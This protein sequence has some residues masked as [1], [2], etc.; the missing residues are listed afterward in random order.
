MFLRFTFILNLLLSFTGSCFSQEEGDES[1][2]KERYFLSA[3]IGSGTYFL[4]GNIGGN[5]SINHSV[6][7]VE[8]NS[9]FTP[10][11]ANTDKMEDIN[12]FNLIYSYEIPVK[13]AYLYLGAGPSLISGDKQ[14]FINNVQNSENLSYTSKGI[15]TRIRVIF[16]EKKYGWGFS[17]I[18]NLNEI[19]SYFAISITALFGQIK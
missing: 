1:L 19:N 11:P 7:S 18:S 16:P 13:N 5:Y 4:H 15:F 3:G 9:A 6:F 14:V 8:I 12:E 17:V 10:K 2:Q